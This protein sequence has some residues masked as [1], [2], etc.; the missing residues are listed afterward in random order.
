MCWCIRA[1]QCPSN[2]NHLKEL[3]YRVFAHFSDRRR[4]LLGQFR[5]QFGVVGFGFRKPLKQQGLQYFPAKPAKPRHRPAENS[6]RYQPIPWNT[7]WKSWHACEKR[8]FIAPSPIG[9][10]L[11]ESPDNARTI[12]PQKWK[13]GKQ[14]PICPPQ[15]SRKQA[16]PVS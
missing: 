16:K 6:C 5:D 15:K 12:P 2:H 8:I 7:A 9:L 13:C 14:Q 10:N 1:L 11:L 4:C 3:P